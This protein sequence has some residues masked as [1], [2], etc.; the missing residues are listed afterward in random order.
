MELVNLASFAGISAEWAIRNRR[1]VTLVCQSGSFVTAILA[2]VS[3]IQNELEKL[4]DPWNSVR[5]GT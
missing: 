4:G 3:A 5:L 1:G 2:Y